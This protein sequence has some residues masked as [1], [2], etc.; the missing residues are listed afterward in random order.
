MITFYCVVSHLSI[1]SVPVPVPVPVPLCTGVPHRG[2]CESVCEELAWLEEITAAEEFGKFVHHGSCISLQIPSLQ[3]HLLFY[4]QH[5]YLQLYSSN[6]PLGA[7][8]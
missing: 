8:A 6:I 2:V 3:L 1:L 5:P 7:S 4:Y